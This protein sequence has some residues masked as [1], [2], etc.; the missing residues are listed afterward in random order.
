MHKLQKCSIEWLELIIRDYFDNINVYK[1][2][3]L[4]K[5]ALFLDML[6]RVGKPK[7]QGHTKIQDNY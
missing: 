5:S 2:L 3:K 1:H 4:K 7:L 6:D